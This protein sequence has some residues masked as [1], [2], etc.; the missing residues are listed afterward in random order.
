MVEIRKRISFLCV[1]FCANFASRCTIVQLRITLRLSLHTL[2]YFLQSLTDG[3]KKEEV[4]FETSSFYYLFSSINSLIMR[5][6][7]TTNAVHGLFS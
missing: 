6:A 1:L 5:A 3:V 2:H 4:S 7:L